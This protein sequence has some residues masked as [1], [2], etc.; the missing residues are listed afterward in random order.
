MHTLL[1]N[2]VQIIEKFNKMSAFHGILTLILCL[3]FIKKT[4][5]TESQWR[6]Y[7]KNERHIALS[8]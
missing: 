4:M 5:E 6:F 2:T 8:S 7:I 3:L 1:T